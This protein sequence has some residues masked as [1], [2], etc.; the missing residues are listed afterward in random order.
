MQISNSNKVSGQSHVNGH[1]Y[2]ID[3]FNNLAEY[4][5]QDGILLESQTPKE[6]ITFPA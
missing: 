3:K 4:F 6:A 5:I 1:L 2:D